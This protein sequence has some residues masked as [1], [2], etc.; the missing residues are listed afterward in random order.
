M[1]L[2]QPLANGEIVEII[3]GK[4]ESPSRDWLAPEQGFL[5]SQR[6]RAKVRA[7]FRKLDAGDNREAGHQIVERELA[8]LGAGS[9]LLSALVG[10]F[11]CGDSEALYRLVGEGEIS[12]Q[13]LSQAIARRLAPPVPIA[14]PAAI[15][16]KNTPKSS[17][18]NPLEIEGGRRSADDAG[19]LLHADAASSPWSA[20]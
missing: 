16:R 17:G 10:E 12:T 18:A 7:W 8:R 13:Q 11:K 6:S 15:R 3:T 5:V 2:T 19:A 1:P 14:P 9:D 4:A 20:T